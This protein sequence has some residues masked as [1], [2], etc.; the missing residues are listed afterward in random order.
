MGGKAKLKRERGKTLK[1][2]RGFTAERA[3]G[4]ER[5]VFTQD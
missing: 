4:K 3:K 2:K 1:E 5:R